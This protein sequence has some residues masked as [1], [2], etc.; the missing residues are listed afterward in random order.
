MN[1]QAFH[2][3]SKLN[4][5]LNI[6]LESRKTKVQ[7]PLYPLLIAS[8]QEPHDVLST[9]QD[10]HHITEKAFLLLITRK[11]YKIFG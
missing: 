1:K 4:N 7:M 3:I 8:N 9:R 11:N 10:H 6:T 2:L 5:K